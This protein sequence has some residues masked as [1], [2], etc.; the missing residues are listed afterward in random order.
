MGK[1]GKY[2]SGKTREKDSRRERKLSLHEAMVS[3]FSGS[4]EVNLG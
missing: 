4:R 3:L 2:S 1:K